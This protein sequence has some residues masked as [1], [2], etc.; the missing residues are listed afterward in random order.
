MQQ[1][2]ANDLVDGVMPAHVLTRDHEIAR[3]IKECS[4]VC[5]PG[6][7]EAGLRR[8]QARGEPVERRC[9]H[10]QLHGHGW[11]VE[12][13]RLQALHAADATARGGVGVAAPALVAIHCLGQPHVQAVGLRRVTGHRAEIGGAAHQLLRVQQSCHQFLV[14]SRRAHGHGERTAGQ[15]YL[16]RLLGRQRVGPL[17]AHLPMPPHHRAPHIALA[18]E[19]ARPGG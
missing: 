12:H 1:G 2:V 3:G 5:A 16:Q 19:D 10:A 6:G 7:A 8:A 11:M 13:Q 15:P 18:K 17:L 9:R 4:G 14:V